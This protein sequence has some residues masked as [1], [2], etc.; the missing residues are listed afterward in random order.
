MK[1][2][3][4][5]LLLSFTGIAWSQTSVVYHENFDLPSGADSVTNGSNN[6]NSSPWNVDNTLSVSGTQSYKLHGNDTGYVYFTTDSFSTVGNPSVQLSF[7]HIAKLFLTSK[8]YVQLSTDGGISWTTLDSSQYVNSSSQ[9][10]KSPLF[11]QNTPYSYF[12]G[13]AYKVPGQNYDPWLANQAVTAQNSW[14]IKETFDL[15]GL[16]SDTNTTPFTGYSNVKIRFKCNFNIPPSGGTGYYDGWYIDNIKVTAGPC[17]LTPPQLSFNFN[18][19][20]CYE[21]NPQ[22]RVLYD[23][24][25]LGY[26]VGV[27][28]SDNAN[29]FDTGLDSVALYY[30][31][32]GGPFTGIKMLPTSIPDIYKNFIT[33]AN[34]GDSVR[35]Y[36]KAYDLACPNVTR[37]P[38]SISGN[39]YYTFRI[40]SAAPAKCGSPYC[41]HYPGVIYQFPWHEN[42]DGPEWVSGTGSSGTAV[43]G[44]FPTANNYEG[45]W[46]VIP[47]ENNNTLYGWSIRSGA[48]PT[49][50]TGPNGD[51]TTGTGK[52]IYQES[53]TYSVAPTRLITPCID[54]TKTSASMEFSFYYH[55]YGADFQ[56]P[57]STNAGALYVD[58]DTTSGPLETWDIVKAIEINGQ[59]QLSYADAWQRA[60]VS[61]ADYNGKVVK[62]RLRARMI[63]T[64]PLQNIA[65]D[66]FTIRKA[67]S[68]DVVI[69]EFIAPLKSSCN[70]SSAPVTLNLLNVGLNSLSSVPM[71]YELDNGTIVRDTLSTSSFNSFD[72]TTFTFTQLLNI[73]PNT[74]VHQLKAWTEI[75]GD[76]YHDNDTLK[77]N[78]PDQ[79]S[80]VSS[81]PYF[82]DFENATAATS[83]APG[84]LNDDWILNAANNDSAGAHWSVAEGILRNNIDGP[85]QGLGENHRCILFKTT[86]NNSYEY[87]QLESPCFD[88]SATG[89]PQL[90][91]DYF[92]KAGA[93]LKILVKEYGNTVWS[94]IGTISG[95][96]NP[97]DPFTNA[98]IDLNS[99]KNTTLQLAFRIY[100][101]SG[102]ES[103][104]LDNILISEKN[105]TDVSI[106]NLDNGLYRLVDNITST[107]ASITFGA[108]DNNSFH[109]LTV[110]AKLINPCNGNSYLMTAPIAVNLYLSTPSQKNVSFNFSPIPAGQYNSKVWLETTGDSVHFNDT[111]Y[112]HTTVS[113]VIQVPFA[114]DFENCNHQFSAIGTYGQWQIESPAKP[115]FTGAHSGSKAAITNADSSSIGTK[116]EYLY[117]PFFDGLDKFGIELR[118][119]HKYDFGSDGYGYVQYFTSNGWTNLTSSG[120]SG[121]NWLSKMTQD[122]VGYVFS[123]ADTSWTFSSYP[124]SDLHSTGQKALR[125]VSVTNNAPGWAIDDFEIYVPPQNSASPTHLKFMS[126]PVVG[127]NQT[128]L[129]IKNTGKA[130]LSQVVITIIDSNTTLA[131]DTINLSPAIIPDKYSTFN[132]PT[133]LNLTANMNNLQVITQF[134]NFQPDEL[135]FDD[136]LNMALSFATHVDSTPACFDFESGNNFLPFDFINGNIDTVWTLGTPGKTNINSAYSGSNSWYI[137]KDGSYSPFLNKYLFTPTIHIKGYTCY[138]FSF[139][140]NFDTETG[141]DGGNIEVSLDSGYTWSLLGNYGDSTWYN[142]PYIQSLDQI[143][144]GFSGNSGGWQKAS[145]VFKIFSDSYVQFR[146]RF[147]SNASVSG[148][149]WAIDN[150]CLEESPGACDMISTD[151]VP[152]LTNGLQLFPNPAYNQITFVFNKSAQSNLKIYDEQGKLVK[153]WYKAINA[154]AKNTIDISSLPGGMYWLTITTEKGIYQSRKFIKN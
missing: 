137:Q 5:L 54:L 95:T 2:I 13:G 21:K 10:G 39:N 26:P 34:L 102:N 17:E 146:F 57:G 144:P 1:K 3:I 125:F 106:M 105:N 119:Y 152:L 58:I 94:I 71:A 149:G 104:A 48:T 8:A 18:P 9:V 75:A 86:N 114:T 67:E 33:G 82:E 69:S 70:S 118:F 22:D 128:S 51:H 134:P 80:L 49:P 110:K 11:I 65:I 101:P 7:Y 56:N 63:S 98:K 64:G 109:S 136:T 79:N 103:C 23:A 97:K 111:L 143:L 78:L 43:R 29:K 83:S 100:S 85:Y 24:S 141:F 153:A 74:G 4:I 41:G 131:R 121:I 60:V 138:K 123:G 68:S 76:V 117:P 124:L 53:S 27:M 42:F 37:L 47:S 72:S 12:N 112:F 150:V 66:D 120:Y 148:D 77:L 108:I 113:S 35:Y 145:I 73:P 40:D 127:N 99:Y 61:L 55:M 36:L 62:I 45:Y 139:M 91:F 32:N 31:I 115:G 6:P 96:Q 133:A 19:I 135:P 107:N 142:T 90:S 126:L 116:Y 52:F 140:Q 154:G 28:A 93:S 14:W 151:E 30:S 92:L 129:T 84:S 89:N 132:L 16:A 122:S 88:L 25:G 81:L 87:A 130:P 50:L 38:D 59:H 20:P 44:V 15:T 46:Q 147:A